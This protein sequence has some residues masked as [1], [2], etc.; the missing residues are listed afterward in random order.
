M[1]YKNGIVRKMR[2]HHHRRSSIAALSHF[3]A[4]QPQAELFRF[5]FSEVVKVATGQCPEV[6]GKVEWLRLKYKKYDHRLKKSKARIIAGLA[7][8]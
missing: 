1:H 2:I 6:V 7:R 4:Q 5:S 8:K 3:L